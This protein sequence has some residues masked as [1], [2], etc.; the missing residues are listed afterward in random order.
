MTEKDRAEDLVSA[1]LFMTVESVLAIETGDCK[2]LDPIVNL[3]E[4]FMN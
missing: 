2:G 4:L 3:A 1:V